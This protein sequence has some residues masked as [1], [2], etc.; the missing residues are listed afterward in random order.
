[1]EDDI[2]SYINPKS[3]LPNMRAI[4]STFTQ[5][6]AR[7]DLLARDAL[8]LDGIAKVY[9]VTRKYLALARGLPRF[10]GIITIWSTLCNELI[11][12]AQSYSEPS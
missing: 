6:I 7:P 8:E 9:H 5:L 11:I 1:M 10:L 12:R 2:S 4:K 3:I